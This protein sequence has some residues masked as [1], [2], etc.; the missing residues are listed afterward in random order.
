MNAFQPSRP[1]LQPV[2]PRRSL[3]RKS[4]QHRRP[5][6][7][8]T[9]ETTA[10]LAVNVLLSAAAVSGLMQL[11]HYQWFQ[12]E[13][14]WEIQTEVKQAEERVNLL[15]TDFSRYFDPQQ[16]NSIMQEQS[17]WVEPGQHQVVWQNNAAKV[18]KPAP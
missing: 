17:N 12:Q 5:Y 4:R 15:R 3:Q 6:Q 7:V 1:P 14:L 16:A 2:E 11:L 18:K 10:K 13:K 9:L 8:V